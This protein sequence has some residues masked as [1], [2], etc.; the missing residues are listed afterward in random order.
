MQVG[1][2]IMHRH[3]VITM[4]HV[5]EIKIDQLRF[6]FCI[7]RFFCV[8]HPKYLVVLVLHPHEQVSIETY[9]PMFYRK[10]WLQ[11][12]LHARGRCTCRMHL[13]G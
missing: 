9:R 12:P 13:R 5:R 8:G 4:P 7:V 6:T 10:E 3:L 1:F 11:E 2:G